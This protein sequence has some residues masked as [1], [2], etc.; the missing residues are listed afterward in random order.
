MSLLIIIIPESVLHMHECHGSLGK[1]N[2]TNATAILA[3]HIA[4]STIM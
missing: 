4:T 2:Y 3:T 1:Y